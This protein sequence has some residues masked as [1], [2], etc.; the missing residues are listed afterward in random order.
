M[1]IQVHAERQEPAMMT[2][3]QLEGYAAR[4][5]VDERAH[6][7]RTCGDHRDRITMLP[8]LSTTD[9]PLRYCPDC[10]TAFTLTGTPLNSPHTWLRQRKS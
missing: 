9:A 2:L 3:A 5:G 6:I 10:L 7:S 1:G 8:T 4:V